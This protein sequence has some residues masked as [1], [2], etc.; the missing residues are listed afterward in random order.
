MSSLSPVYSL[1][2]ARAAEK[3]L[4]QCEQEPDEL[5]KK[6]AAACAQVAAA[7]IPDSSRVLIVAGPGGNGGDGL[8]AG[9]HLAL[10]G[11]TVHAVLTADKAHEAAL[12]TF[13]LP[14]DN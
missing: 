2:T 13:E 6:A 10:A 12:R 14:V 8:F 5:M 3:V 11:H 1:A 9:T 7:M 4:L